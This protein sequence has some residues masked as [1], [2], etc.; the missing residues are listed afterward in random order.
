MQGNNICFKYEDL[1]KGYEAQLFYASQKEIEINQL[2]VRDDN[3][4]VGIEFRK[5]YDIF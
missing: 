3:T 5:T 2:S 1:A 4:L